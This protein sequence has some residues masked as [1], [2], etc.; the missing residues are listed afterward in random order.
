[1]NPPARVFDSQA[2]GRLADMK[3]IPT[4]KELADAGYTDRHTW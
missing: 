2:I 1:M 4:D 3:M